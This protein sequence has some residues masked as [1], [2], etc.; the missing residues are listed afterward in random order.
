M[1]I[2][3]Q[4]MEG[5]NSEEAAKRFIEKMNFTSLKL[6]PLVTAENV[7]RELKNKNIDY[8][9]FALENVLGGVVK[10]TEIAMK[11]QKFNLVCT[12]KINIHHCIFKKTD[13]NLKSIIGIA[14]HIQALKQTK[15]NRKELFPDIKEI[16]VEDTAIAA[17]YL[18]QGK[19]APNVAVICRKE[20]GKKYGLEL[21]YENIE[22]NKENYTIFGIYKN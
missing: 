17:K 9:V 18:S 12:E 16:E 15:K 7:A 21:I 14:S 13:I 6:I 22:D 2:G 20:A 8:G 3:Y 11:N 4:G 5:S 1:L 19:L 10:E